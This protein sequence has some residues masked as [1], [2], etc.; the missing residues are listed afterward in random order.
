MPYC[1]VRGN[2]P[3]DPE[4]ILVRT[5]RRKQKGGWGLTLPSEA[6]SE[7]NRGLSYTL[8][9][10]H[11]Q[12]LI[13]YQWP[14]MKYELLHKGCNPGTYEI[15]SLVKDETLYQVSRIIPGVPSNP[16]KK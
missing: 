12:G 2:F 11:S 14:Y 1:V 5:Q 8:G 7:L 15:C 13:N 3:D 4:A 6:E 10:V 16:K 9:L